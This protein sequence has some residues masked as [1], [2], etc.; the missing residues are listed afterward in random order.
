MSIFDGTF[1]ESGWE[2]TK[3]TKNISKAF[4]YTHVLIHLAYDNPVEKSAVSLSASFSVNTGGK[5][6]KEQPA[7]MVIR[8]VDQWGDETFKRSLKAFREY[9]FTEEM[10]KDLNAAEA[11]FDLANSEVKRVYL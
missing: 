7:K 5:I 9:E 1:L 3:A 2:N 4:E 11:M 8:K 10:I 6:S